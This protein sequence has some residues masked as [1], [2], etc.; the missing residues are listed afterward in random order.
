M[1]VGI[2]VKRISTAL[3]PGVYFAPFGI[4]LINWSI[5]TISY[6]LA[7]TRCVAQVRVVAGVYFGVCLAPSCNTSCI[8]TVTGVCPAFALANLIASSKGRY[9]PRDTDQ[10][11]CGNTNISNC[12]E[13]IPHFPS[14]ERH[15]C[16]KNCCP[17][18]DARGVG[19]GNWKV[20]WCDGT[21]I[22]PAHPEIPLRAIRYGSLQIELA[23]LRGVLNR[24]QASLIRTRLLALLSCQ[25]TCDLAPAVD[26]A[27]YEYLVLLEVVDHNKG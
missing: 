5:A 14:Q 20:S 19:D 18:I 3:S 9:R 4:A 1:Q 13:L 22:P 26:D 8:S 27:Q 15:I 16:Q 21:T 7:P 10:H 17:P 24:V 11:S 2:L 6:A 25:L 12:D 23:A